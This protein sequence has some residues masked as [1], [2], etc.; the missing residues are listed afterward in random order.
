VA[1]TRPIADI[2]TMDQVVA[3]SVA[4]PRAIALLIGGLAGLA[5]LLAVIGLYGVVSYAAT[6]RTREIGI[7]IALGASGMD[8]LRIVLGQGVVLTALGLALGILAAGAVQRLIAG[9]LYGV[10]AFDPV[11]IGVVAAMLFAV[12]L[13]ASWLPG[14]RA[15]RV[16]P[17]IAMRSE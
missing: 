8:V 16:D 13:V 14:R 12:S 15:T 9:M 4:A 17:L 1:P 5:L 7:R 3:T 10:T 11:T 2:R 6:Q